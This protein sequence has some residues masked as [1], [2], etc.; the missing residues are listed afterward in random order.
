MFQ[1][2][3]P[4]AAL[5]CAVGLAVGYLLLAGGCGSRPP[6]GLVPVTGKVTYDD[7]S[8]IKAERITI[9]F[10]PQGM[11]TSNGV[12]VSPSHGTVNVA[13]GT[14]KLVT[15]SRQGAPV[16]KFK[17][18]VGAFGADKGYVLAKV[19]SDPQKTPLTAEVFGDKENVIHI[20]V[21]KK[22]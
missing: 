17:V 21:P 9:S 8:L 13:D 4:K 5:V 11:Q 19:L 6:V 10:S 14:F 16:G 22:T 7:G 12:P 18:A 3:I 20:K 1:R 2:F 15:W